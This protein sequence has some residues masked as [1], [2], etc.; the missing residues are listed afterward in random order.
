MIF[1]LLTYT[2]TCEAVGNFF[3]LYYKNYHQEYLNRIIYFS[4]VL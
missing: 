3:F 2:V 1:L 4:N